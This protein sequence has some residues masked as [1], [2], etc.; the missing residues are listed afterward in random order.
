MGHRRVMII[1]LDA[2]TPEL[3]GPWVREGHLPTLSHFM[4]QGASGTLLSTL[5]PISSA[6]WSTFSTGTNPGKHGI[7]SFLQLAPDS[8]AARVTNAAW[9]RGTTFWEI[10]GQ[11]GVRGGV[12][13]VPYTYPPRSYNGFLVS[14]FLTP[15]VGRRM[16]SPPE[17]FDDLIA[18]S[19][20]YTPD[21][22]IV[23]TGGGKSR[24]LF[25]DR[26]LAGIR[27][28]LKAAIG[29]YRKHR[30]GLFCVVFTAADRV[31]HRFWH[32]Y[33]AARE[34]GAGSSDAL[35][36]G[37]ILRVYRELD[38]AVAALLAEADDDTDVILLSDHGSGPVRK[39]LNM[40]QALVEAGLLVESSSGFLQTVMRKGTQAFLQMAPLTLKNKVKTHLA[41]LTRRAGGMLICNGIDFT[42]TLAYPADEAGGVFVNLAG[43]QPLGIVEGERAYEELRDRLIRA[44]SELE[45]PDTGRPVARAV[46]RREEV[47]SGPCVDQFPD[48]VFEPEEEIYGITGSPSVG[49]SVFGPL[50]SPKAIGWLKS[51]GH[52]RQGMVLAMGPRIRHT[53]VEGATI[54]DVPATALALL[55]CPVGEDF[56]GRVLSEMLTE[57]VAVPGRHA[58]SRPESRP[59]EGLTEEDRQAV[60]RRLRG[61]GY[62]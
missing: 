30:P 62:L 49:G 45:D 59:S 55:G 53:T 44:L 4:E 3:L 56:D 50:P 19:G 12:I 46:R 11:N 23:K 51:G 5:P 41:G 40:R 10:A 7:L 21:I 26:A 47:W 35:P 14:G 33:E 13:N 58:Q 8:Y 60:E 6:A 42:R 38:A 61:L 22:E 2:L 1:G 36:G 16:A 31:C 27:T 24:R 20:D 15:G 17:V 29:L 57:E 37:A 28:R 9:R 48:V 34:R 25:L 54:A 43:R 39:T 32:D 52:T 18:L